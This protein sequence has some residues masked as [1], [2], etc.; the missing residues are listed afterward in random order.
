MI[1]VN[2]KQY[3][4]LKGITEDPDFQKMWKKMHTPW[5]R[6]YRKISPNEVCPFCSSG[7]KFKK[8]TCTKAIGYKNTPI[9]TVNY[10]PI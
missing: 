2:E 3:E 4:A 6:R 1:M 8:C 7:K 10:E 9:L 5:K